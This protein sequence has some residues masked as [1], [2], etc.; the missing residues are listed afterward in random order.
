MTKGTG[1]STRAPAASPLRT[2]SFTRPN[3]EA[4]QRREVCTGVCYYGGHEGDAAF[5]CEGAEG[6]AG[7]RNQC[8]RISRYIRSVV[9][10]GHGP[11]TP[12][13]TVFHRLLLLD[14]HA[15]EGQRNVHRP[16]SHSRTH[17][18]QRLTHAG[19]NVRHYGV[20]P[21]PLAATRAPAGTAHLPLYSS[22]GSGL[23]SLYY[24]NKINKLIK[25]VTNPDF[26]RQPRS[27]EA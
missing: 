17:K 18:A 14:T 7:G 27:Y 19:S 10:A 23:E 1:H 2:R 16:S 24:E 5:G 4:W 6:A 21:S 26:V 15:T 12:P 3:V 22:H 25:Y 8:M 9:W 13:G 11:S 20:G